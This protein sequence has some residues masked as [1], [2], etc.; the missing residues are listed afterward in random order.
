MYLS[1]FPKY[2]FELFTVNNVVLDHNGGSLFSLLEHLL[3]LL[4]SFNFEAVFLFD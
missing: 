1:T 4:T 3:E 2:K